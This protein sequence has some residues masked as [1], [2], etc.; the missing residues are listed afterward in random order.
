MAQHRAQPPSGRCLRFAAMRACTLPFSGACSFW[1]LLEEAGAA[2]GLSPAFLLSPADPDP[3]ALCRPPPRTPL[4]PRFFRPPSAPVSALCLS[5]SLRIW[6]TADAP[7]E[8]R[9]FRPPPP[10][11]LPTLPSALPAPVH[12]FGATDRSV[13]AVAPSAGLPSAPPES[14][15]PCADPAP[16]EFPDRVDRT[17]AAGSPASDP[18]AWAG[19][20]PGPD[21]PS[22]ASASSIGVEDAASLASLPRPSKPSDASLPGLTAATG[23][24]APVRDPAGNAATSATLSGRSVFPSHSQSTKADWER[25]RA[26]S[27][28]AWRR[29][30]SERATWS[31]PLLEAAWPARRPLVALEPPRMASRSLEE[32][33]A[34][35]RTR[36]SAAAA[37]LTTTV[38]GPSSSDPMW[39]SC[40]A[41]LDAEDAPPPAVVDDPPA[42]DPPSP[43]PSPPPLARRA[44]ASPM[45][46]C[47]AR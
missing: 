24:V 43:P 36:S 37:V 8:P 29:L 32:S 7:S 13:P 18:H 38:E 34:S 31:V 2:A 6:S 35:A 45:R 17:P 30:A 3:M 46:P 10:L 42:V 47:V 40:A 15:R 27:S 23:A 14:S 9:R 44:M 41:V 21:A 33:C 1:G 20:P 22:P 39:V 16:P 5:K 26:I 25:R 19:E 4:A 11:T 12:C 28:L